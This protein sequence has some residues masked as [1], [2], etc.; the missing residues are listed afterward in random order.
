MFYISFVNYITAV[1]RMYAALRSYRAINTI[2]KRL[3]SQQ[4]ISSNVCGLS[5]TVTN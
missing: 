3:S 4:M 1:A 2:I 5:A